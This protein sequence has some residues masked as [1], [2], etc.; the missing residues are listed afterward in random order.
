M[1]HPYLWNT[2]PLRELFHKRI[3]SFGHE[4]AIAVGSR[5]YVVRFKFVAKI[6]LLDKLSL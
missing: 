1:K 5:Q 6:T 2:S 3:F 4:R